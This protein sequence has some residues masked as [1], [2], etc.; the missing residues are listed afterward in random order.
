VHL[1]DTFVIYTTRAIWLYMGRLAT[2]CFYSG[3]KDRRRERGIWELALLCILL[4]RLA[5]VAPLVFEAAQSSVRWEK[6]HLRCFLH[7]TAHTWHTYHY[8]LMSLP[9]CIA[10]LYHAIANI[11]ID[12]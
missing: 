8:N 12:F 10:T 6:L 7:P 3:R 11:H 2:C 1:C 5:L 4:C 9:F